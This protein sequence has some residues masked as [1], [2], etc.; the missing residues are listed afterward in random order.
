MEAESLPG[1]VTQSMAKEDT[2]IDPFVHL[3]LNDDLAENNWP[4]V[5]DEYKKKTEHSL[6]VQVMTK[7]LFEKLNQTSSSGWTIAR[8][9]NT[10]VCYP[11]SFVGCHAGDMDSYK[12]FKDLFY[13]VIEKYHVGYKLDGSMK[14]V[15]NMD[16]EN[17]EIDL[18]NQARAI[19]VSTRIR[20]ARNLAMY[21]LN[22]NGSLITRTEISD[23]MEAIFK[24]MSNSDK[25]KDLG[26]TFFRHATMTK[27][28]EQKL[29]DDHFLFK[30]RDEMQA[31]SGYHQFWP[32]GRGIFISDDKKFLVWVNEGDHLRIISMEKSGDIKGVMT[33]LHRGSIAIERFLRLRYDDEEVFMQDPILGMITCCPSNLGTGL[34]ASVHCRLP[35][36]IKTMGFQKIDELAR[37]MNCQARGTMGEHSEVTDTVDLSNWR[38]LGFPEYELVQDMIK[39]INKFADM[40]SDCEDSGAP[41]PLSETDKHSYIDI[42]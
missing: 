2:T 9:I 6:M 18:T 12:V 23:S 7:E 39:C 32:H 24:E 25:F 27:G 33:R 40:E 5:L 37:C 22:T 21:P 8:S 31:A 41:K 38:R 30:G 16:P 17:I 42:S 20:C 3:I 36:L 14:H 11:G 1:T 15:T 26:G 29:I 4:T 34:R 19:I 28:E 13:P 35:K 10:G